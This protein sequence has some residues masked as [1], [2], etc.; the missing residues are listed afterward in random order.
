MKKLILFA[1]IFAAVSGLSSFTNYKDNNFEIGQKDTFTLNAQ[2]NSK[3]IEIK[4]DY[5]IPSNDLS[6][7]IDSIFTSDIGASVSITSTFNKNETFDYNS[8][9]IGYGTSEEDEKKATLVYCVEKLDKTIEQRETSYIRKN[10]HDYY[11]G[12]GEINTPRIT[13]YCD[14]VLAPGEKLLDDSFL[15]YNYFA[16]ENKDGNYSIVTENGKYKG[17]YIVPTKPSSYRYYNLSTFAD[18]KINGMSTFGGYNSIE[19]A[20]ENNVTDDIYKSL[21]ASTRRLYNNNEDRIQEG[22]CYI[23]TRFNFSSSSILEITLKN[24]EKPLNLSIYPTSVTTTKKGSVLN[25][26]YNGFNINDV[27]DVRIKNFYMNIDIYDNESLKGMSGS[28]YS[29]RFSSTGIR[30]KDLMSGDTVVSEAN[31]NYFKVDINLIL[32]ITSIVFMIVYLGISIATYFYLKNKNKDD[33]FKRMR[34]KPYWKNNLVGLFTTTSM[35]L[36][37]ETIIFRWSYLNNSLP[38]F[39]PI[40]VYVIIFTVISI[41]FGGYFIRYF[42]IQIKN[43][44]DKNRNERMKLKTSRI[45][46]GALITSKE[47]L[48]EEK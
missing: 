38:V 35:L 8:Y 33:E 9:Y 2:A 4:D 29:A 45:D 28:N 21:S 25:F 44:L 39:N 6:V 47:E 26:L 48:E 32:A 31:K 34:S 30:M 37:I 43:I 36:M 5:G 23:R 42:S 11:D 3:E 13:N 27:E 46:E 10:I 41:I 1:T 20:I 16:C 18:L 12:L 17:Y 14:I 15:V 19:I 24:E 22:I 7:E 40:D